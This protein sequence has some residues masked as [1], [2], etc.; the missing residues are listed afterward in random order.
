MGIVYKAQ[1]RRLFRHVAIKILPPQFVTLE[2]K[3]ARFIQ[4]AR[5]ASAL[6][7]P[8]ICTI[9]DIGKHEDIE[10]IVMEFME[11]VTL[12][13]IMNQRKYLPEKEV[14]NIGSQVCD[15]LAAAHEKG[16]IHRDIKPENIMITNQNKVKVLDFGLAKLIKGEN[17]PYDSANLINNY[18]AMQDLVKTN[19][20]T[21]QGT[22]YYMAPEQ[23][24]K[25]M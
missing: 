2:K 6:N 25:K 20:S 14:V 24:E 3:R 15:A 1:D 13:K 18:L 8:N 23:I 11:G 10:F 9:Y 19:F 17:K 7:H 5:A 21:F 12:R 16:I 22:A 4:E